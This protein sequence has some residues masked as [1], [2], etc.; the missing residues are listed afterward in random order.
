MTKK[1]TIGLFVCTILLT[2]LALVSTF[3]NRLHLVFCD[4]G[5]GDGILIYRKS[6]QIVV[7]AGPGNA[8]LKCLS[9][10]VP[11]WD[12]QIEVVVNTHPQLDHFGGLIN[13]FEHYK[14]DNFLSSSA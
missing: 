10:H 9:D 3:D 13:I 14:V 6:V 2:V 4:V 5:Q 12:R 11:F 1:I 8:Y 7:D